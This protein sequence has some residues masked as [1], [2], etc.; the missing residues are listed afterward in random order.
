MR[1]DE[2]FHKGKSD[3]MRFLSK[4]KNFSIKKD[5][6]E[7]KNLRNDINSFRFHLTN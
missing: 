7:I 2:N 3:K 1:C 6:A 4:D 5:L